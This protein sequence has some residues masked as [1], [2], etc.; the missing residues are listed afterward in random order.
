VGID[1]H[2]EFEEPWIQT[3]TRIRKGIPYVEIEYQIGPVPI[4]DGRGKEVVT[5][6]NTSVNNDA[7][8]YTDSNGREFM[9]RQRNHRPT[10][11][12]TI[13]EPVAGNYYPINA[14]IYVDENEETANDA[15][16]QK[17][18]PAFAVVTDRTQGGG[19]IL[20]GTIELM[21]HRRIVADDYR[22]VDEPLN[23]TDVGITPCPPYGNATRIG[24]GL[25]IRGKHRI[26]VEKTD[27]Q[28]E[29]ECGAV[30]GA[31]L[32]RSVMDASFAEPLVFVASAPSSEEIPF[33]TKSY[34][35]L[36]EPLPEN[37]ML[38]T[39]R[40]L[41]K[42]EATSY[43]IRLGHQYGE[44]VDVDLSIL[45]P[46]QSIEEIRETTLSGNRDIDDWRKERFDWIPSETR[47]IA[48]DESFKKAGVHTITLAAMD[49]R[50]VIVKV[51]SI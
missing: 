50:T 26:L 27:C 4:N 32:A 36:K 31:Q 37:V 13:F 10:W 49:I 2:T 45:F 6:Y 40:L 20:D 24:E 48:R 25:V 5:R 47:R 19:S 39:K 8:F 51:K 23:E 18:G 12:L 14:A 28:N 9:K 17:T 34:S 46:H 33:L 3:T 30:G 16:L 21:V 43:L 42:E 29:P 35:G 7:T 22:G 41:Y 1:I 38:I 15:G 44:S 11:D